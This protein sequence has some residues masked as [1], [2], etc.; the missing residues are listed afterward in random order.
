M[1]FYNVLSALLFIGGLRIVFL[2]IEGSRGYLFFASATLCI[3]VFNDML[4]ASDAFE[5][6]DMAYGTFLK[7]LDLVNFLLLSLGTIAL[8]PDSNLYD[9]HLERIARGLHPSS[10]WLLLCGYWL[11]LMWWTKLAYGPAHRV[12]LSLRTSIAFVFLVEWFFA[13]WYPRLRGPFSI[14][15]LGYLVLYLTLLRHAAHKRYK[16][17][18]QQP[19]A[20]PTV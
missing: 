5:E 18:A 1:T 7:I 14:V 4:A 17:D 8:S 6:D 19:L 11:I 12:V 16:P 3:I 13:A 10:F 15:V 20:T 2:A 9:L